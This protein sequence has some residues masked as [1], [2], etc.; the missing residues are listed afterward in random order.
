MTASTN[1]KDPPA[2]ALS[3]VGDHYTGSGASAG[4]HRFLTIVFAGVPAGGHN[5]FE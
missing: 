4:L 2:L 1:P 3:A 5:R